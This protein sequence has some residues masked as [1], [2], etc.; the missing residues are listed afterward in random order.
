MFHFTDDILRWPGAVARIFAR[1][2]P[3]ARPV[4]TGLKWSGPSAN[5]V[6]LGVLAAARHSV[7]TLEGLRQPWTDWPSRS[8]RCKCG[9]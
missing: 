1:L 7:S 4:A 2:R 9:P 6:N 3:G 5:P 8:V